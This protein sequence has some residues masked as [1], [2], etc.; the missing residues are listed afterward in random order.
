M[1]AVHDQMA[2][3]YR[4]EKTYQRFRIFSRELLSVCAVCRVMFRTFRSVTSDSELV[5]VYTVFCSAG[6][7]IR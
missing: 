4:G 6:L 5:C 7:E 3:Q 2:K 1:Q